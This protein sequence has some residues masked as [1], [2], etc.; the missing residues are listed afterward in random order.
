MVEIGS[1]PI[2]HPPEGNF[3][4]QPLPDLLASLDARPAG[5]SSAAAAARLARFGPNTL[6]EHGERAVVLQFL[7]RLANPLVLVLLAA[8][9]VAAVLGDLRSFVVIAAIVLISLTLD[10]VQEHRAGRA[11]EALRRSV[12]L[13]ARALRDGETRELPAATLVPGDVIELAAGDLAPA[14]GRVIA[15]RDCFVNQAFLTGESF[16]VE[17]DAGESPLVAEAADASNAV[18]MGTALI[19]GSATVLVVRTGART[20]IGRI[21]GTLARRKPPTGF[22][23]GAQAF[24]NMILRLT[25]V[26]VLFVLLANAMLGRPLLESFLFAVALAVGLTP[27]LLP[28]IVSVTLARGALRMGRES[29]VV[30]RLSAVQDLGAIDVLCTDKTGT[31]TST[32]ATARACSSS[33]TATAVSRRACAARSTTRSCATRRSTSPAGA[34]STRCRSTSSAGACRCCSS[35]PARAC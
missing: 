5:L 6:I 33:P 23:R 8:S 21:G 10:F 11:A 12:A 19:S 34:R 17:K 25:V 31:S 22:E 14:D 13:T 16:P 7:A 28:M 29:V 18:F 32:A 27:E 20:A 2:H 26:L 35:T 3:W 4:S 24:G 1:D 15:A 9:G 30:K